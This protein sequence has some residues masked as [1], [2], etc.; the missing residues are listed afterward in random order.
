MGS[1]SSPTLNLQKL[2][3]I[4]V[5]QMKLGT[6]ALERY[7][8]LTDKSNVY[9]FG[10]VRLNSYHQCPVVDINSIDMRVRQP[11]DCDDLALMR[12]IQMPPSPISVTT[13]WFSS[14]TTSNGPGSSYEELAEATNNFSHEKELGNGGFGRGYYAKLKDGRELAVKRF[15][16]HNYAKV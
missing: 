14:D 2:P 3:I 8:M 10:V 7:T 1:L 15:H 4:L 16:E 11:P 5:R 6:E 12:H 13:N 9:S